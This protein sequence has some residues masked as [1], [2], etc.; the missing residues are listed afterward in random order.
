[1]KNNLG[2]YSDKF[3]AGWKSFLICNWKAFTMVRFTLF[4]SYYN[5]QELIVYDN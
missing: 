5:S 3:V 1:M 4:T 2:C